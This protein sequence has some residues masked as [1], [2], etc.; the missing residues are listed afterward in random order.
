MPAPRFTREQIPDA[1]RAAKHEATAQYLKAEP[2][3]VVAAFAA[4]PAPQHNVVGVGIGVKLVKGKPTAQHAIRFYV[5]RKLA[6][7]VIPREFWLPE[8]VGGAPTDVIETGLFRALPATGASIA[9]VRSRLR[10]AAPG[11]SVGFQFTGPNAGTVMAGT[12]GALVSA[13]GQLFNLSN[14][15]VLA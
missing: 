4:H 8:R 3:A 14:N 10:P 15:Q 13:D 2:R 9:K 12:F 1:L 7:E 5:E 6:K 11:C